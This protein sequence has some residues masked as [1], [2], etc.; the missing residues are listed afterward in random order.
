MV[1][2]GAFECMKE[3][4]KV[5]C[6]HL[7]T[8]E[9]ILYYF[10]QTHFYIAN[11]VDFQD[12][13]HA[14]TTTGINYF[15]EKAIS[16]A[17]PDCSKMSLKNECMCREHLHEKRWIEFVIFPCY[18]IDRLSDWEMRNDIETPEDST[19]LKNLIVESEASRKEAQMLFR[20]ESKEDRKD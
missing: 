11:F 19:K 16:C 1:K 9:D 18:A 15:K 8:G 7:D 14:E 3:G 6:D 13:L 12:R 20:K 17:V 4:T 10:C 5:W 2:C